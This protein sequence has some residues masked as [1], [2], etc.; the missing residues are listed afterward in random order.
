MTLRFSLLTAMAALAACQPS[1]DASGATSSPTSPSDSGVSTLGDS[2]KP[3]DSTGSTEGTVTYEVDPDV[4]TWVPED[5]PLAQPPVRIIFIGDSITDGVGARDGLD[6]LSLLLSND[7][8]TYPAYAGW[9]VYTM[10]GEIQAYDASVSGATTDTVIDY[11]LPAL[12]D[13]LGPVVEGPTL[14]VGTIGG[15]DVTNALFGL[16][17]KKEQIAQNVDTIASFFLD[18]ERFV[19]GAMVYLTNVYEPTDGIG[20]AQGCFFNLDLSVIQDDF[21]DLNARTRELAQASGWAWIDLHGHFLGHGH[22]HDD[23]TGPFYDAADPTLWLS[24]D[25]IHPNDRGHHEL[26]RLFLSAIDNRPLPL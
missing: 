21:D 18:E 7:D 2:S 10:F 3:T 25:C 11:Q 17:G 6:Y 19:D 13:T 23:E 16:E 24:R 15:N 12:E 4:T 8:T 20:Q 9:D 26:R 5:W 22:N 14:V 1:D